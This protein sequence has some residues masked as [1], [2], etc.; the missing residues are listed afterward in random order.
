MTRPGCNI[1]ASVMVGLWPAT[2]GLA[3]AADSPRAAQLSD[4][5]LDQAAAG[6][7]ASADGDGRATGDDA[8]TAVKLTSAVRPDG[9][10]DALAYGMV[11]ANATTRAGGPATANTS[12]ILS[13]QFP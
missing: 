6:L 12:L 11:T 10:I 7:A 4:I 2:G 1:V 8:R 3:L 9:P 13:V 5:Q